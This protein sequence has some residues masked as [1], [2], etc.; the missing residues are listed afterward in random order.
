[1]AKRGRN[2]GFG[3]SSVEVLLVLRQRVSRQKNTAETRLDPVLSAGERLV[4]PRD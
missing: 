4:S 3:K 1:M 2:Q